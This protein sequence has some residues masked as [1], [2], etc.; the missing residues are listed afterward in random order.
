MSLFATANVRHDYYQILV[1]P[2]VVLLLSRGIIEIWNNTNWNL[3]LRRLLLIFSLILMLG[4]SAYQVKDYYLIIHPEIVEAGQAADVLIPK[5]A[6]VIA[7]YNGD[8][9]FLYQTKRRGWPVVELPINELIAEG[10]QYYVSVNFDPQTQEFI[11][12]F[13]TVKKTDK[14]VILDLTKKI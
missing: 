6:I 5:D 11:Q 8:T 1:I 10:A 7:P 4:I 14:Y 2:V 3:Y 9:A 13:K 12:K